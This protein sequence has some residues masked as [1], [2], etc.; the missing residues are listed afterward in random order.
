M[1]FLADNPWKEEDLTADYAD[2]R[3]LFLRFFARNGAPTF[4]SAHQVTMT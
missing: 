4:L 2:F 3:R 1:S